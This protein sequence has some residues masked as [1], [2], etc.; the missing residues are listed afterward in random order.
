MVYDNSRERALAK[1]IETVF[2][3][4]GV[5]NYAKVIDCMTSV[6]IGFNEGHD[7]FNLAADIVEHG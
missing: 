7:V 1:Y 5:H 4:V 6:I 3:C 2:S